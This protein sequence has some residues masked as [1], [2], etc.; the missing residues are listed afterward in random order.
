[1]LSARS[2]PNPALYRIHP[3]SFRDGQGNGVGDYRGLNGVYDS[4]LPCWISM[5]R[6]C[7]TCSPILRPR[8]RPGQPCHWLGGTA[9]SERVIRALGV[10]N[11][12][13]RGLLPLFFFIQIHMKSCLRK[14]RSNAW[15]M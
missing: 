3:V 13:C 9:R 1:M 14:Q 7:S 5:L 4:L 6:R 2:I 15:L 11:G 8:R 10:I 12:S